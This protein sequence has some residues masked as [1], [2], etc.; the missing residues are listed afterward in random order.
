MLELA[1][2]PAPHMIELMSR[3][4]AYLGLDLNQNM[5]DFSRAKADRAGLSPALIRGDM[6]RFT[7]EDRVDFAFVLLGSLAAGNTAELLEHLES[8]AETLKSGG[9]YLLDWCVQ[10][11]RLTEKSESWVFEENEL[12]IETSCCQRWVDPVGQTF[13]EVIKM[14]VEDRGADL[15]LEERITTRAIYPQEF[16]L[17]TEKTGCFEFIGWWNNW[18]LDEPMMEG[19]P[20]AEDS[21][22]ERPI[23]LIRRT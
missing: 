20:R 17:L 5:L 14:K 13:E 9:I 18:D 22:I 8:V 23:I 16:L 3:G 12:R 15:E 10:F 4:Y 1:C 6:L 7:L 11:D 21:R 19:T 2:G